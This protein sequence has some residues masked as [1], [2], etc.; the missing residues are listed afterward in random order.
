MKIE[1]LNIP[2]KLIREHKNKKGTYLYEFKR[3]DES[4]FKVLG[5]ELQIMIR[6]GKIKVLED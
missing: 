5:V 6:N 3:Q 2:A 4:I 1:Y